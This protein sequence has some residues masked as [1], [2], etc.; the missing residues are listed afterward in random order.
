MPYINPASTANDV[1]L[2]EAN[3]LDDRAWE[4][5]LA[6]YTDDA[7][8]WVPAWRD[9]DNET[10]DPRSEISQIY[11]TSGRELA[12][13][14]ER[15]KSNKSVTTM[16]LPRT[17]H[18]VTNITTD[19]IDD[20]RIDVRANWMVQVY[21]PRTTKQYVNFGHY[22][23]QLS[24]VNSKWLISSKKIHLKNDLVPALIDFYTL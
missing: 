9:E 18:F 14:I 1:L 24:N 13:R 8:Y 20:A 4:Q 5:W 19:L 12:E 16:P 21:Q 17:T 2:R 7:I 3:H 23:F 22:E 15:V 10:A 11:H 6:L